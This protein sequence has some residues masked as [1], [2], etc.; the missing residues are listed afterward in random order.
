M[1]Y[2]SRP[3]IPYF[4]ETGFIKRDIKLAEETGARIH[5]SHVSLASSVEA[6]AEA[7]RR[8]VAITAEATP[9][10]FLL[11]QEDAKKIGTNAKV[12]PPSRSEEDVQAVRSGL[13]DGTIDVIATDHAPH[14]PQEKSLP[15]DNAPFGI[16]GLETALGLVLTFLVKPGLLTLMQAI[17][18]MSTTPARIF[19]LET[20][21][22][23][24]GAQADLTVIDP[25]RNWKVDADCFY[26]KGRNCPFDGWELRG[27][28][29]MTIVRGQVVMREGKIIESK[30]SHNELPKALLWK[31]ATVSR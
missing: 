3:G 7:K 12:N 21:G 11:T 19:G 28:S 30:K 9:H 18:K 2:S 4:S 15:W 23:E 20:G 10:H 31:S 26:S 1:P 22:F 8:G 6:I 25:D 24:L 14:S 5:I 27:K 17:D 16:I 29:V 13:A